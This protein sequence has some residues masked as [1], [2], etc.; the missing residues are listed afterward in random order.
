MKNKLLKYLTFAL[1]IA[2][3]FSAVPLNCNNSLM[4]SAVAAEEEQDSTSNPTYSGTC[5]DDLT[6]TLCAGV[7][8]I[9]GTGEMDYWSSKSAVPWYS[10]RSEINEVNIDDRVTTLGRY[11]CYE[12]TALTQV[13]LPE[14][15]TLIDACAFSGASLTEITIPD[16][17]ETIG[18]SA[19][20][21]TYISSFFV[22]ASVA[23]LD[24]SSFDSKELAEIIVDPENNFYASKDSVLFDK[25]ITK[26][27]QYPF[28]NT[29]TSY[30]VPYSVTEIS[31]G[32]FKSAQ[33]LLSITLPEG[34][35]TIKDYAFENCTSL[36]EITLPG[37]LTKLNNSIGI[38]SNCFSLK[39]VV[40]E[41]GVTILGDYT[42]ITCNSLEVVALPQ[43]YSTIGQYMFYGCT[44][45]KTVAFSNNVIRIGSNAFGNCDSL[46][47]V[48]YSGSKDDWDSIT[49]DSGNSA[50]NS[51]AKT[52]D[53]KTYQ[54]S[55]YS[56]A[57]E[58]MLCSQTKY[59]GVTYPLTGT[60]PQKQIEIVLDA[61]GGKVAE[62][63][64]AYDAEFVKWNS[65]PDM[66]GTAFCSYSNFANDENTELYA[67][68]NYQTAERLPVPYRENYV[69]CGW[70]TA[71]SDGKKMG[72]L[73]DLSQDMTL[74][75]QWERPKFTVSFDSNGSDEVFDDITVIY[76]GL[77]GSLP[78]PARNGYTFEGW[79]T[80]VN[81]GTLITE[82]TTVEIT[83]DQVLYAV[84]SPNVY[85]VSFDPGEGE[86]N[87]SD[88][89][90][91]FDDCYG[92]LPV[93]TR[94]G[95]TFLGWYKTQSYN[96]LIT[97]ESIVCVPGDHYLYA[98]WSANEYTVMFDPGEG[99]CDITEKTVVFDTCYGELPVAK[100]TGYNFLGWFDSQGNHITQ[101]ALVK[102]TQSQTF[103]A[104]WDVLVVTVN[105]DS[106]DG[107][108]SFTQKDIEYGQTY[109]ELPQAY[110]D[111]MLFVGWYTSQNDG[112]KIN[113]TTIMTQT[114]S[115][116]LYAKFKSFTLSINEL[117]LK[118]NY[119][120]FEKLDLFGLSLLVYTEDGESIL[121]DDGFTVS[122]P[123][124]N[125]TGIKEVTVSFNGISCSFE[126]EV[127]DFTVTRLEISNPITKNEYFVGEYLD[128]EGLE[129]MAE[130]ENGIKVKIPTSFVDFSVEQF[131]SPGKKLIKV[132][133]GGKYTTFFVTVKEKDITAIEITTLPNKTTYTVGDDFDA[134]GMELT[135]SYNDSS[136]KV[137][138]SGYTISCN[139][140]AAGTE[141][142]TV[143]YTE[144]GITV[145]T[146]F[147]ITVNEKQADG[148]PT[149]TA[150]YVIVQA[151]E[152]VS[153][154][155]TVEQNTGF[156]GFAIEISY[157]NAVLAPVSVSAGEILSSG[158]LNDSIGGIVESG[159]LKV[160]FYASENI[161]ADG[162]LF[163][164]EFEAI[165]DAS[166]QLSKVEI[167]AVEADCFDEN[168]DTVYFNTS[169]FE[170]QIISSV[171]TVPYIAF[172]DAFADESKR[173]I[174]P[175]KLKNMLG[176]TEFKFELV[177]DRDVMLPNTVICSG[178]PDGNV[179]LTHSGK[180]YYL[181]WSGTK[182]VQDE[183]V[184]NIYFEA[185]EFASGE[186]DVTVACIIPENI[187]DIGTV[188]SINKL[189]PKTT[190]LETD[191]AIT[192]AGGTVRIPVYI[193]YNNGIMGF[194][195]TVEYDD[196][197]LTPISVSR[198]EILTDGLMD[199]N[200]SR[201][202]GSF[203][204]VWNN[205]A[206]LTKDGEL[207]VLEFAVASNIDICVSDISF[208]YSQQDTYNEAWQ[209]VELKI[210]NTAV[211]I[212][213]IYVV[214]QSGAVENNGYVYGLKAGLESLDGYF[215]TV[216]ED[217]EFYAIASASR[218]GS[219]S[220]VGVQYNGNTVDVYKTILFG[221]V[222]G[223]GW[224]DGED[225]FLVNLIAKG[226]L[227][228]EDVGEAIWTAADCNHDGVIDEADVDLL[229]GAGLKLNDVNQTKT[230]AELATNADY[231][232]YVMLIDQSAGL[233]VE[234]DT[235]ETEQGATTPETNETV[236]P[237]EPVTE[238]HVDFEIIF[239]NIFD[240]IKKI[241]SLIFSFII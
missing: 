38:F 150:S 204:I 163:T 44:T 230:V 92:Q 132:Y 182:I 153:V 36:T 222:N 169:P 62:S 120:L 197:I 129:I 143:S 210:E 39:K 168:W 175:L 124:M 155:F 128:T 85:T 148:K 8:T 114:Q 84:W 107:E 207:L 170:I 67:Q 227:D 54:L 209:D 50:L 218:F 221:D 176:V 220:V 100:R 145:T 112:E 187:D 34:L 188:V 86:C 77:Y 1:S 83:D 76:S 82:Q 59:S 14:S 93:P 41:E 116:T 113:E 123:D 108:C 126:I 106:D 133:Y 99:E 63:T 232:E 13:D 56:D 73:D 193:K 18:M 185:S 180:K 127:L 98:L 70:Y 167:K 15:L 139:M 88:K 2:V 201:A 57:S 195:L 47:S 6:W 11:F 131:S 91:E 141:I 173:I 219:G 79:H 51:T 118:T 81:N 10:Y 109:S 97:E 110:K 237:D 183:V 162:T 94:I 25:N 196:S 65:S 69:F 27:I 9:S 202:S 48:Y 52:F 236:E 102:I 165:K 119:Y 21:S 172:A 4:F 72:E 138:T 194:G 192:R 42:F 212:D 55:Y 199:N 7:L 174:L 75:A 215:E 68:W 12:C 160:V 78:I 32:A 66:S 111:K 229:S 5:G 121:I 37:T 159:T 104:S 239:T 191:L 29:R 28:K 58:Q 122:Q 154:P 186:T 238:D 147:T 151:G 137:I 53:A 226:L 24:A 189:L 31:K 228:E 225:A 171:E 105:F 61:N 49:I 3:I 217:I 200:I 136:T 231:I 240:F 89:T 241:L 33:N 90:I 115:H 152:T 157:D 74:L 184:L 216:S 40:I 16:T 203:K 23:S 146:D 190:R 166:S 46:N 198:G 156:M 20:E 87:I 235:D 224:Y 214:P 43:S 134:T 205:T 95:Y 130:N 45:L 179:E 178:L 80:S 223:D 161:S 234:P 211:L 149:I 206:N 142:V 140:E 22:P 177:C 17:V 60:I 35:I 71:G 164:V 208:A 26:L 103:Y 117:P 30:I 64:F 125:T 213:P 144:N 19:F 233:N 101:D 96:E 181:K 135:A 158:N